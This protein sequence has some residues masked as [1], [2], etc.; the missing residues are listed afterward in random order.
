[1]LKVLFQARSRIFTHRGG[2]TVQLEATRK[3]LQREGVQVA[4]SYSDSVDCSP[5]DVVHLFNLTR[6]E[7]TWLQLQNAKRQRKPVCLSTIYWRSDDAAGEIMHYR[8]RRSRFE[9]GLRNTVKAAM[10]LFSPRHRVMA[11]ADILREQEEVVLRSLQDQVLEGADL[12]LPNSYMELEQ[13]NRDFPSA[14]SKPARVVYNG[15]DPQV[16][17]GLMSPRAEQLQRQWGTF[18]LCVGRIESRKNQHRLLRAMRSSEVRVVMIGRKGHRPYF[19][20]VRRAMK[21]GDVLIEEVDQHELKHHY[22]AARVHVLPSL[23]ETPGLASLEAGAMGCNVVSGSTGSQTEYFGD[24]VDWCD[25]YE[26]SSIAAAVSRALARDWPN[27]ALSRHI[28]EHYTWAVAAEQTLEA[29]TLLL[30]RRS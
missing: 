15:I 14:R 1:M 18:V 2:D 13:L 25:P 12:L 23:Y 4:F 10:G 17:D 21:P 20:E 11:R 27:R 26:E 3:F 24:M 8:P 19:E 30:G 28:L 7:E 16:F 5:Y 22:A 9:S 29:Y 6:P